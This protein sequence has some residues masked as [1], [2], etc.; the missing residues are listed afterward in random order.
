MITTIFIVE[1]KRITIVN[2]KDKAYRKEHEKL[3]GFVGASSW[4]T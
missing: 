3:S 4:R 1:K 2:Q